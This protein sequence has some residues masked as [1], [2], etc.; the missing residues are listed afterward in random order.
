MPLRFPSWEQLVA[1]V[2]R[3]IQCEYSDAASNDDSGRPPTYR[4]QIQYER[5]KTLIIRRLNVDPQHSRY[6]QEVNLRV[7]A[8]WQ[9]ILRAALY[10]GDQ[11]DEREKVSEFSQR[12]F[13]IHPYLESLVQL[14]KNCGITISYNFD[15][16]IERCI[17][18]TTPRKDKGFNRGYQ[19][20]TNA[21]LPFRADTAVIYHP[22]GF[23]PRNPLERNLSNVVLTDRTFA[24]QLLNATTG[25]YAFLS[26]MLQRNT[27]MLIGLSLQDATLRHLLRQNAVISPGHCHYLIRYVREAMEVQPQAKDA[28]CK[29]NFE[30]YSLVTLFLT[31]MQIAALLEL[32]IIDELTLRAKFDEVGV[33]PRQVFYVT[34]VTGA[35]KTTSIAYLGSLR[36]LDE[37]IDAPHILLSRPPRLMR[38]ESDD[39]E[40]LKQEN[41]AEVDR[42]VLEQMAEKNR[43]LENQRCGVFVVDRSTLDPLSYISSQSPDALITKASFLRN[44]IRPGHSSIQ[45]VNGHVILLDGDP[46]EFCRRL[47]IRTNSWTSGKLGELQKRLHALF[48][49]TTIGVSIVNVERR[50]ISDG[51]QADC[52]NRVLAAGIYR[53]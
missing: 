27:C 42:W 23:L 15:D 19:S 13:G 48:P 12:M 10:E 8:E 36:T 3:Q 29:A 28:E 33:R 51:G 39:P 52:R 38:E 46:E 45:L 41:E 17:E 43:E 2:Q 6:P 18:G 31:D 1:E 34:G 5:L 4:I 30:T 50:S 26:D 25:H 44:T 21:A 22:N 49:R 53:G 35:G 24:D 11:S 9:N 16:V 40:G 32:L 47:I 37:W 20:V 14:V 7:E